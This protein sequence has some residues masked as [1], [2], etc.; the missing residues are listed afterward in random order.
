MR[1]ILARP[2]SEIPNTEILFV[3]SR[4]WKI[5]VQVP[6]TVPLESTLVE[7]NYLKRIDYKLSLQAHNN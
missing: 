7:L 4:F 2:V 3:A 5:A 1:G 6:I